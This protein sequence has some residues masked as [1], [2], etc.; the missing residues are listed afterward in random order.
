[1][2]PNR[3]IDILARGSSRVARLPRPAEWPVGETFGRTYRFGCR[4]EAST[5]SPNGTHQP[6]SCWCSLLLS[7]GIIFV[8]ELG[9]KSQLMAMT[10]GLRYPWSVVLGGITAATIAVHLISVAVGH[11][12]GAALPTHLIGI[13]A[14]VAFVVRV[15]DAAG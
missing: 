15:V 4:P 5:R 3:V 6:R 8:A 10:F 1:V 14:G 13:L 11:Y 2:A 12:L 7:F 9:D